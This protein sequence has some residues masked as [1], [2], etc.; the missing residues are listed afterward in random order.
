MKIT[1]TLL[2]AGML[3]IAGFFTASAQEIVEGSRNFIK[4][5][6]YNALSVVV[7]GQP[8]NVEA[9]LDKKFEAATG[10]KPKNSKGVKMI[11][12]ASYA[13][14]SSNTLDMFYKVEAATKTDNNHTR[15]NLFLS[16][17][18]NNF[19]TSESDPETM[20]GASEILKGLQTE[21]TIY[22][23]EL[24]IE[25]QTKVIDK[26][27]K[28]HEKMVSDSVKLENKLAETLQE[29]ENNK[30]D[31]RNQ[32]ETI[33]QEKMKLAG[34]QEE[35]TKVISGSQG[36]KEETPAIKEDNN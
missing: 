24:A 5:E 11:E 22:E 26:A 21:V 9:V 19:I 31:R 13:R 34:F 16:S 10:S 18:N 8:K 3:S 6:S 32:L 15:V 33:E 36:I 12:G 17:G 35:M 28:D 27:I 2:L 30:I 1:K 7:V 20:R 4:N 14:M 23:F 29:I 25:E